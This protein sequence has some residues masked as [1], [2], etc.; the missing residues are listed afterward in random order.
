MAWLTGAPSARGAR[1]GELWGRA[2]KRTVKLSTPRVRVAP[3]PS[4]SQ[5]PCA[6]GH[7]A[8]ARQDPSHRVSG[9]QK[10]R[11]P[12]APVWRL[13]A[14]GWPPPSA[15]RA[16]APTART[17]HPQPCRAQAHPRASCRARP[18]GKTRGVRRPPCLQSA[19]GGTAAPA[20]TGHRPGTAGH[21]FTLL[22]M[23]K[24]LLPASPG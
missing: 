19:A 18:E 7:P 9:H 22:Q 11:C 8:H 13:L 1:R 5:R 15:S 14:R 17:P 2:S 3:N 10:P 24:T 20:V 4:P 21:C 23:T 12:C 6:G 16:A